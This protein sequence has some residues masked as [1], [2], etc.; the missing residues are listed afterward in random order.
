[1]KAVV[2]GEAGVGVREETLFT[3]RTLL[4]GYVQHQDSLSLEPQSPKLSLK[5]GVGW[6]SDPDPLHRCLARELRP[7][8]RTERQPTSK[9]C[10]LA[11]RDTH[12]QR[13]QLPTFPRGCQPVGPWDSA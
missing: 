7:K 9:H 6:C 8:H 4:Q 2:V 13:S 12:G 3:T 1:M 11:T 10:A 5:A